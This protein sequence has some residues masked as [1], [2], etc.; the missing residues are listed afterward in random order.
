MPLSVIGSCA[1]GRSVARALS[2]ASPGQQR[3]E[4]PEIGELSL[5]GRCR[6]RGSQTKSSIPC[7]I[8][9]RPSA[10]PSPSYTGAPAATRQGDPGGARAAAQSP[11]KPRRGRAPPHSRAVQPGRNSWIG[12]RIRTDT[13][14]LKAHPDGRQ[15]APL[16]PRPAQATEQRVAVREEVLLPQ[17]VNVLCRG[18]RQGI[19][20]PP[21]ECIELVA[22]LERY[23]K[24][25]IHA[26]PL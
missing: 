11:R 25:A 10:T 26:L 18:G 3:C 20:N 7:S 9:N 4:N 6:E 2:G 24:R 22:A 14:Y 16:R 23:G 8:V 13:E 12:H 21:L 19:E 15:P 17:R 5:R 1:R